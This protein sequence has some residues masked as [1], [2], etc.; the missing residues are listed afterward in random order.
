MNTTKVEVSKIITN[1]VK[2]SGLNNFHSLDLPDEPMWNLPMIGFASGSDELFR[3]YKEH[4]GDFYWSPSEA[5]SLKYHDDT[6]TDEDLTVISFGFAQTAETKMVQKQAEGMPSL[7]WIVTR[8]EWEPFIYDVCERVLKELEKKGIRAV[9]IDLLP[10]W[11]RMTSEKLGIAS[12]W[13][14]R[15][16][17]Y[18]AGLGTFGLSDGLITRQ[19]KAMR[20]CTIIIEGRL[21]ADQRTYQSH[22]EWCKFY[23]DGTCG[24]CIQRCPVNAITKEGHDK[25]VCSAFLQKLKNEIGPDILTKSSYISGCG[26]CQSRVPCQDKVPVRVKE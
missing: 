16:T 5:F 19:G 10:E 23:A 14:H 12:K 18:A 26:L 1:A 15:H 3:F 7:R 25:D 9:A 20:F 6:V 24:A 2:S 13:S 17:A 11:S 22:Y 8:G 4:I 21:P